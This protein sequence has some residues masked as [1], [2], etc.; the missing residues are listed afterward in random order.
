MSTQFSEQWFVDRVIG[1]WCRRTENAEP[2]MR[3]VLNQVM[4]SP[5]IRI[6]QVV[7][8]FYA[9]TDKEMWERNRDFPFLIPPFDRVWLESSQ[10]S[11][12]VSEIHGVVNWT[13][14]SRMAVHISRHN[15]PTNGAFNVA[16]A[17]GGSLS[18]S[19]PPGTKH[20]LFITLYAEY[21]SVF[22]TEAALHVPMF[23]DEFGA[24]LFFWDDAGRMRETFI[25]PPAIL[26]MLNERGI[27]RDGYAQ[28]MNRFLDPFLLA[29]SFLNCRNAVVSEMRVARHERRRQEKAGT[30]SAK[31]YVLT[32]D[33]L[34]RVVS[35]RVAEAGESVQKA[36]HICRGHFA[37]YSDDHPL[38]GKH[39]GKFWRPAHIRGHAESGVVTKDY[40]LQISSWSDAHAR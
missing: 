7:E 22:T 17:L 8:Y 2:A 29:L 40:S 21:G 27:D 3:S 5:R 32:I 23:L 30:A 13:G 37:T 9:G 16:G 24:P 36:L 4:V 11:R 6:D 31:H 12:I 19:G 15:T 28:E 25:V 20:A 10:P 33:A 38:F 18:L 39:T 26:D 35:A 14:P 34:K 1:A